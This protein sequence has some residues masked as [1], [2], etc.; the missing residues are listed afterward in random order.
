MDSIIGIPV[1]EFVS[2][3]KKCGT[4]FDI[5]YTELFMTYTQL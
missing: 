3:T 4:K 1:S 5:K 2:F